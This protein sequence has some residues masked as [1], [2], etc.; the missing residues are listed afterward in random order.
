MLSHDAQEHPIFCEGFPPSARGHKLSGSQDLCICVVGD[1]KA[2]QCLRR[3]IQQSCNETQVE[4]N[5]DDEESV[6]NNIAPNFMG[7][8]S[9]RVH[10]RG[11]RR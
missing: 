1:D 11:S 9:T 2:K 10:L 3:I 5:D 7:R 6:E 8:R 4:R